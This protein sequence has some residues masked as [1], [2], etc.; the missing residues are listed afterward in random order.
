ME[1]EFFNIDDYGKIYKSID[2]LNPNDLDMINGDNIFLVF[3]K[4]NPSLNYIAAID[5]KIYNFST[6][7]YIT[8]E[9]L[10]AKAFS[11]FVPKE[12]WRLIYIVNYN[13]ITIDVDDDKIYLFEEFEEK[14]KGIYDK[15]AKK[16]VLKNGY[17]TQ[18]LMKKSILTRDNL[19]N[20]TDE[21]IF[22]AILENVNHDSSL[23]REKLINITYEGIEDLAIILRSMIDSSEIILPKGNKTDEFIDEFK[24]QATD[25]LDKYWYFRINENQTIANFITSINGNIF[26]LC[27]NEY[28]NN[29]IEINYVKPLKN[30]LPK[31][32]W[33]LSYNESGNLNC[34]VIDEDYLDVLVAFECE[35]KDDIDKFAKSKVLRNGYK[36]NIGDNHE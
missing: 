17:M 21:N 1:K 10:Y 8:D 16:K 9:I 11:D 32:K 4:D 34:I 33:R 26:N 15:D 36:I 29:G 24:N 28:I 19:K 7:K 30:I 25:D 5:G 13:I 18:K 23:E 35:H 12:I 20:I 27:T 14:Y 22:L 31:N 2:Y 6:H 3:L